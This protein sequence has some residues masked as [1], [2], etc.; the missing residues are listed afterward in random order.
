VG[1]RI[2]LRRIVFFGVTVA[3]L[4]A[5][6]ARV[7]AGGIAR[8][9]A[10]LSVPTLAM[11]CTALVAGAFFACL[12]LRFVA[13]DLGSPIRFRDAMTATAV[14]AIGGTVFFSIFGQV[15]ARSAVLARTGVST[16]ATIV[17][18]GYERIIAALVSFVL[19][20][21]GA[22]YLFGHIALDLRVGG[23]ELLKLVV[24]GIIVAVAGFTFAWG[25]AAVAWLRALTM[26]D[27]LGI[28]RALVI[29]V[30]IQ[31]M[32]M[33][34]YLVTAHNLAPSLPIVALSAAVAVI[35]FAASVPISFAGWGVREVSAV[36]ALGAIKMPADAA[37]VTAATIG[38]FSLLTV[39]MLALIGAALPRVSPASIVAATRPRAE[40]RLDTE[41]FLGALLAVG[42][43]TAVF[44]QIELP[45]G[46]GY[47]NVNLAD[48]LVI[49][50]AAL[51][52]LRLAHSA[53]EPRARKLALYATGTSL[54][55]LLSF[56][57]GWAA[58]GLTD[59]ALVNRL[60]G[61]A[62][63]LAYFATGALLTA[64]AGKAG[65]RLV[66]RSFV[67]AGL[68][69]L[70]LE[71]A[72]LAM[73]FGG[74]EIPLQVLGFRLEG[75]AGNPN[76]FAF[77][78]LM[79]TAALLAYQ[80][81]F[82]PFSAIGT[83]DSRSADRRRSWQWVRHLPLALL[84]NGLLFAGSR[85]GWLAAA[86][87]IVA[88]LWRRTLR[89][90]DFAVSAV[91]AGLITLLVTGDLARIGQAT[92]E[93]VKFPV[94]GGH[95]PSL[96][97]WALAA[98]VVAAMAT[99]P[100]SDNLEHLQSMVIGLKM[101]LAHPLF[102]AG[103][104]AFM[105]SYERTY[106][107]ALVIH[108]TPIWLLAETGLVGF[109]IFAAAFIAILKNELGAKAARDMASCFI[110][111]SLVGFAVM[112]AAHDLMYQR[113]LWLLIGAALFTG[114]EASSVAKE[115]CKGLQE[116]IRPLNAL[117]DAATARA[118]ASDLDLAM[119]NDACSGTVQPVS[120]IG[121]HEVEA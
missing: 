49:F 47:L 86:A 83:S 91:L 51:F 98:H 55:V 27:M 67:A 4:V 58:F 19:A 12:R 52:A 25:D 96:G 112:G 17:L 103:L 121:G 39:G 75:F 66:L 82:A 2:L 14:G 69:I 31:G 65:F 34:A 22:I 36:Y 78:L 90:R 30:A 92:F 119:A 95:S 68:A 72:L 24:A 85:A 38:A 79:I 28:A 116:A 74:V 42:A 77:Q 23:A 32:T 88:A 53:P 46:S 8:Q 5:A 81:T 26:R 99:A 41:R 107:H 33:L 84:F 87:V 15:L 6:L 16:S 110:V 97:R 10:S 43:A 104:G 101:W 63:L 20:I 40:P 94:V 100:A 106:G 29:S 114:K 70:L 89:A 61:W 7:D 13:E 64:T 108:S 111:L 57:H 62:F 3:A 80:G 102:G 115:V 50:G 105:D 56:L 1:T 118:N 113:S 117:P 120:A 73:R 11:L 18:T 35:M 59:W 54:V 71:L 9:A 37:I 76:A 109:A 45:I 44:F 60:I 48:G 21:A 93:W